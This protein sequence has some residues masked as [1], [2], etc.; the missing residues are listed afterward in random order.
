MSILVN[1]DTRL[2]MQ[3]IACH[4]GAMYTERMLAYGTRIVA[5]VA[6]GQGGTWF[7]SV[8]VFDTV[9]EAV[10]ATDANASLVCMPPSD[11][12][13]AI[14]EAADAGLG[15]IVCIATGVPV[16]D[17]VRVKAY[18]GKRQIRLIGPS[19]PGVFSPGKCLAGIIAEYI[20]SPGPVAVLSRSGSL[21]YEVTWLLTKAGFGQ[22]TIL[23]IGDGLIVGTGFVDV[24]AMVEDDPVTEQIVVIGE[25]GGREEEMAAAFIRDR[26][27]KP[28][29]AFVAGHTAPAGR[30][31]GHQGAIIEGYTGT[32]QLKIDALRKAGARVA[33]TV[34]EIPSLLGRR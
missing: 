22:S 7:S 32:A 24:L 34:D 15:L 16:R 20:L 26:V 3:G 28:V 9:K 14:L 13:D 33:R 18:L 6:F 25:I 11:A 31:M 27:S 1:Q 8:P 30:R 19:S 23:G 12:A 4:E 21:A 10:H 2:L 5:G 17:M 29:V